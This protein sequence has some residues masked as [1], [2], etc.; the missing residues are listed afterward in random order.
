[1][2]TADQAIS[3]KQ[4]KQHTHKSSFLLWDEYHTKIEVSDKD[5][6][7]DDNFDIDFR[8]EENLPQYMQ[9]AAEECRRLRHTD[10]SLFG[11]I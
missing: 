9:D 4:K 7:I 10:R 1:M 3:S 2:I 8:V 11:N 5:S 6:K